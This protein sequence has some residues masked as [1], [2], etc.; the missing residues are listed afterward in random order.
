MN[1]LHQALLLTVCAIWMV[2]CGGSDPL[3]LR[4]DAPDIRI[5]AP[6]NVGLNE[7]V[8]LDGS[9]S[10]DI[11]GEIE[12]SSYEWSQSENDELQVS[13]S[14]D[15][16]KSTARFTTPEIFIGEIRLHFTLKAKDKEGKTGSSSV[17][18]ILKGLPSNNP[19]VA[20]IDAPSSARPES[21]VELDGLRSHYEN[22][23]NIESYKWEQNST[24]TKKVELS[25]NPNTPGKVSFI[26]PQISTENLD[27]HFTLIVTDIYGRKASKSIVIRISNSVSYTISGKITVKSNSHLDGD[28]NDP[29]A[30]YKP[31]DTFDTAQYISN[32]AQV[33]GYIN[34]KGKGPVGRSS[35]QGD[36]ADY[37][38]VTMAEG[39]KLRIQYFVGEMKT[40]NTTND[41]EPPRIL[42]KTDNNFD[43]YIYNDA[44][45][46]INRFDTLH[47]CDFV[48]DQGKTDINRC[49]NKSES[50]LIGGADDE[51]NYIETI[52]K[53]G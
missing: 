33:V 38:K 21:L 7:E 50:P 8:V 4:N 6:S 16:N 45:K 20:I 23:N 13:L 29:R 51:N 44:K 53:D 12:I 17:V 47:Y 10:S 48:D 40:E 43:I 22:D 52:E 49:L 32:P 28:I 34:R 37:Y 25:V 2:A 39:Q 5:S 15:A 14:I 31:N 36:R 3:D 11:D 26:S 46:L 35:S 27:L 30:I 9:R 19:V 24:D 18:V 1:K 42:L 41:K